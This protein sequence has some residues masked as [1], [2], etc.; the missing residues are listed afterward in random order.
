MHHSPFRIPLLP[1]LFLGAQ[2]AACSGSSAS[3]EADAPAANPP[4]GRA[5]GGG[6][7]DA[8][9]TDPP[10]PTPARRI[11]DPTTG[12]TPSRSVARG[13]T[14]SRSSAITRSA[15][16]ARTS[17]RSSASA[18]SLESRHSRSNRS[19]PAPGRAR[20]RSA[21]IA[22]EVYYGGAWILALDAPVKEGHTWS[23]GLVLLCLGEG[24]RRHRAG[25]HLRRLLDRAPGGRPERNGVLPRR[26]PGSLALRRGGER[27]RRGAHGQELLSLGAR[28][29]DRGRRRRGPVFGATR[30]RP[31][32]CRT[33]RA[34]HDEG[35]T[36]RPP[37]G[38]RVDPAAGHRGRRRSRRSL[39]RAPLPERRCRARRRRRRARSDAPTSA[40]R[41]APRASAR[42]RSSSRCPLAD[43]RR[44]DRPRRSRC[45]RRDRRARRPRRA[46]ARGRLHRR[47]RASPRS[48][49]RRSRR[50]PARD[51]GVRPAAP[52]RDEPLARH[53]ADGA[54]RR[55]RS[56]SM[57]AALS[58]SARA[59]RENGRT[60]SS[61]RERRSPA[62]RLPSRAIA[63]Q[64]WSSASV[65]AAF[66]G[67]TSSTCSSIAR[68]EV[69]AR[70]AVVREAL[71]DALED[72]R[73]RARGGARGTVGSRAR[74]TDR[75]T[76]RGSPD[77]RRATRVAVD[78]HPGVALPVGA[79][80]VDRRARIEAERI[81]REEARRA[82]RSPRKSRSRYF[83]VVRSDVLGLAGVTDDD[84][85]APRHV[86]L[87][88]PVRD[89][90]HLIEVV[91]EAAHLADALDLLGIAGLEPEAGRD[92]GARHQREVLALEQ[93]DADE[94]PDLP[95]AHRPRASAS[96]NCAASDVFIPKSASAMNSVQ[97]REV[98]EAIEPVHLLDRLRRARARATTRRASRAPCRTRSRRGSRA[99]GRSRPAR[100]RCA[101]SG[102]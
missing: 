55:H 72:R 82:A 50:A 25:G 27:L 48:S 73:E 40:S 99:R 51:R 74:A 43:D 96:R 68:I 57:P 38:E 97:R 3:P 5:D 69:V 16:R 102:R 94:E 61:R 89:A 77:R 35:A 42:S 1:I 66:R 22:V 26:R 17:D 10:P 86:E 15:R 81:D 11:P 37:G 34:R 45:H 98:E 14:T 85:R 47:T 6:S 31:R 8:S 24:R 2:V 90:H 76:R 54:R 9:D 64:R 49:R 23:N 78:A 7:P 13:P 59:A 93:I 95:R 100:R 32:P 58:A 91:G 46:R 84:V 19:A 101:R 44:R 80:L 20:T 30:R 39:S 52:D 70:R 4:A 33:G 75:P 67:V 87:A 71:R 29:S 36:S 28:G 12:S 65:R 92:V 79:L 62:A 60:P 41:R 18:T 83:A 21:A 56:G 63:R 88:R 53:V